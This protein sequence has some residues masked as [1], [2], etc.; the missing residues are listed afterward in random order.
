MLQTIT[1]TSNEALTGTRIDSANGG[2]YVGPAF[3]QDRQATK[4]RF[5]P[6]S[7]FT[8]IRLLVV[9]AIIAIL[10]GLLLPALSS[11]NEKAN[12]PGV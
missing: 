5:L 10:A 3:R 1:L 6:T 12:A 8:L 9:I 2:A 4:E 11:A 7:G